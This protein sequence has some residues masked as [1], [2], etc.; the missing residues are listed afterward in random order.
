[1]QAQHTQDDQMPVQ[2]PQSQQII[3]ISGMNYI[4]NY[5]QLQDIN[6]TSLLPSLKRQIEQE[7]LIEALRI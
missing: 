5:N 4:E 6:Q 1:M 3:Q 7:K 2:N